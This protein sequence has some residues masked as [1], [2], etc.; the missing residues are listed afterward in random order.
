MADPLSYGQENL[1]LWE[2]K[3]LRGMARGGHTT[4]CGGWPKIWCYICKKAINQPPRE[5][6][7]EHG[8]RHLADRYGEDKVAA[9]RTLAAL[10]GSQEVMRILGGET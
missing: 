1:A 5:N 10:A 7:I 2:L 4:W 6:F 9:F 3:A 8:R